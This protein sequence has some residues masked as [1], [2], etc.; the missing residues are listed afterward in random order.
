V[1]CDPP[2]RS[3]A[4]PQLPGVGVD[5]SLEPGFAALRWVGPS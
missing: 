3:V 5:W 4:V 2:A 1:R